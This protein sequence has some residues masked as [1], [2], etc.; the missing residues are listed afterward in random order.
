MLR[1][2]SSGFPERIHVKVND[3][4]RARTTLYFKDTPAP[5]PP[6]LDS[7]CGLS[8]LAA[9]AK[10]SYRGEAEVLGFRTVVIQTEQRIE[11]GESFLRTEWTAP[12]L[13]CAILKAVEDRR[14]NTGNITGHFEIQAVKVTV[15]TPNPK[16]FE[17]PQDY[18]E[19][20]PSQ[21]YEA[22]IAK[23]DNHG[24]PV[25]ENMRRTLERKDQ[26]YY[27]NHQAAGLE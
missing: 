11:S 3:S 7:Q 18:A 9:V 27:A 25:S 12:D 8:R 21:M 5:R 19:K 23:F 1:V 14:D 17:V 6:S 15:G 26:E 24:R 22:L 16:L 4:L 20:S 10:P 13:D 2:V